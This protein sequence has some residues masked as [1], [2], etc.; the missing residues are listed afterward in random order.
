MPTPIKFHSFTQAMAEKKHNLASD[1]LKWVL[2]N[3]APNAATDTQ[4]SHITQIANGNGYTTGGAT[5]TGVTVSQSGGILYLKGDDVSWTASGT[6]AT[7]RY[8]ILFNDTATNDELIL[9]LDYGVGLVYTT[10][11][12]HT[13]DIDASL[14]IL[15]I[16]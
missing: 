8:A 12:I 1:T 9:Y 11:L 4:L 6:M 10:G 5:W 7:L 3:T 15:T 16:G 2:S 13:I 14:G